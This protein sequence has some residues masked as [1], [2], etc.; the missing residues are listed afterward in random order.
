MA[1]IDEVKARYATQKLVELTQRDSTSATTID[2]TVLGYAI[3]DISAT[4]EVEAGVAYDNSDARHVAVATAGVIVLLQL[5]K[6]STIQ[7]LDPEWQAWLTRLRSLG[8]VTGRNRIV[9]RS[10]SQVREQ[11]RQRPVAERYSD[12]DM[13]GLLPSRKP[14]RSQG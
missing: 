1:L 10:S 6:R 5:W 11:Q 13:Q 4:F 14:W 3:T 12:R 7:E 8:Q 2:D 9:M